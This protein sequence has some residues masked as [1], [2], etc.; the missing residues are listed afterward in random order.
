MKTKF[1]EWVAL[2]GGALGIGI[3]TYKW[4][5]G[6]TFMMAINMLMSTMFIN[7]YLIMQILKS[8]PGSFM[9]QEYF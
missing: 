3:A 7:T 8:W 2:L 4:W 1:Y 9:K 5:N 6:D